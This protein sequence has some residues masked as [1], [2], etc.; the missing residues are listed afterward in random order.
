LRAIATAGAASLLAVGVVV[1]AT[2]ATATTTPQRVNIAGSHPAWATARAK[3]TNTAVTAGAVTARIYLAAHNPAGLAAYAKAVSTPGSRL[4]GHYL[5]P[6]QAKRAFG[7]T[8]AQVEG[9]KGWLTSAGLT[10]TN[11]VPEV[12]GYVEVRGSADAVAKAFS[13]TFGAY[14][15]A[16]GSVY[17]APDQA[18]SVPASISGDIV[19]VTG[20]DTAKHFMKPADTLPPPPGNYFVGTPCAS[21]F[22]QKYATSAPLVDGKAQPEAVCGYKP[23]QIRGAYNVG[24]SGATGKGVKVAVIDA[25]ASPTMAADASQYSRVMGD[26]PFEPGQYKQV[27]LG[28]TNG[29]L[30]TDACGANGWYGEESLDVES[31]HG[32]APDAQ[33][34][35]VGAVDCTDA[36]LGAALAYV[37]NHHTAD[38]VTNSWGEPYDTSTMNNVYDMIFQVGAVEGIGFFFSSGDSGYEDPGNEQD[39]AISDKLQVDFPTSSPWVTAVGGT[40]LAVGK[41]DN[42]LFETSWG[43]L[44]TTLSA[45]GK[46]WTTVPPAY[47]DNYSYSGGGGVSSVY[48][49]PFYQK[50]VVPSSLATSLPDGTTSKTPM[51]VI[52]DVSALADPNLGFSFGET[53]FG[54]NGSGPAFYLSRIGGT[55]LASP[56]FAGIEADAQQAAHHPLGFANPAI[57]ALAA[58][59]KFTN[60]FRDVTDHPAGA[61]SYV[62]RYNLA[63]PSNDIGPST[64]ILRTLGVNGGGA[65]ALPAVQGY[66]DAT[67]VGSPDFYIQAF[68]NF[69]FGRR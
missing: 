8:V 24:S 38:I 35:Y 27:L 64:P 57:Y 18:A 2:A 65:A 36:G 46:S 25:Y 40:S 66:D 30:N 16:D 12:G 55:S 22:G 20:L 37:V 69:G 51:R 67:G 23:A 14:R 63:D 58:A 10:V 17:R 53:V 31:V 11:V 4:Y 59:N 3:V 32:M 19:S 7:P 60:A 43:T 1:V 42:Y 15:G 9:V 44:T 54:A 33:V 6:A 62:V 21:Y 47:P 39:P 29:W 49:Q 56:I 68:R 26:Q 13:I 41:S 52:P 61:P 45:N 50:L 28:G 48:A 34:T 5:T